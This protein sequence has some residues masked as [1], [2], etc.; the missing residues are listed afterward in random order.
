[1]STLDNLSGVSLRDFQRVSENGTALFLEIGRLI[2]QARRGD[3][4]IPRSEMRG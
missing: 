3:F 4:A 1:M 2:E